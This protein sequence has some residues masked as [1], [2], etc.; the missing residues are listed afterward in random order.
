[1]RDEAIRTDEDDGIT[2]TVT[3]KKGVTK[4]VLATLPNPVTLAP[5]RTFAEVEQPPSQYVFRLQSGNGGV[6]SAALFEVKDTKWQLA[7]IASVK[8]WLSGKVGELKII[9]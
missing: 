5:Y 6:P 4:S 9:A 7:A 1:M 3:I 8:A 2:Q